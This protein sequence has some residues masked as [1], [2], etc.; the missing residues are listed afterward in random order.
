MRISTNVTRRL[1]S[2]RFSIGIND[3]Q[4]RDF[5][6]VPIYLGESE[7][8]RTELEFTR[9]EMLELAKKI[10]H[11]ELAFWKKVLHS[12]ETPR[13]GLNSAIRHIRNFWKEL[14]CGEEKFID[15]LQ[16]FQR[17]VCTMDAIQCLEYVK[18]QIERG[19]DGTCAYLWRYLRKGG[20]TP[21]DIGSS[22]TE[23]HTYAQ[24]FTRIRGRATLKYALDR[25]RNGYGT[26]VRGRYYHESDDPSFPHSAVAEFRKAMRH[27][28]FTC[29]DLDTTEE[30]LEN[31][32][33]SCFKIPSE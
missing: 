14:G 25:I 29:S 30:E 15:D 16:L 20:L 28:K 6:T 3:D 8:L 7:T 26:R 13:K 27:Y 31:L 18:N 22:D 11:L 17:R 32:S 10:T 2:S 33:K 21:K 23:L 19:E 9:A 24:Q 4:N 5:G 12:K 1:P